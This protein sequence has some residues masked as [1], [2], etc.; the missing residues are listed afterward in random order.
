M[1]LGECGVGWERLVFL[2]LKI[3]VLMF[4]LSG[5]MDSK[6]RKKKLEKEKK[7]TS[8]PPG[9]GLGSWEQA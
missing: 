7:M 6:K 1:E 3:Y 9:L 8:A 5:L 4:N 2:S